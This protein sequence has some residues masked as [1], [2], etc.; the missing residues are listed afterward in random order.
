MREPSAVI[1]AWRQEG[2][3]GA[4]VRAAAAAHKRG[5]LGA[6][7][8]LAA[9][10]VIHHF[11]PVAGFVVAGVALLFLGLALTAPLTLYPKVM[12]LLDRFAHAVGTAFTWILMTV[13]YYLFFLP[14]GLLLR[15]GHKLAITTR[16]ERGLPSY[17]SAADERQRAPAAYRKQF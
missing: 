2:D 16:F 4:R 1:W 17:W 13:L 6:A 5:L 8:G 14:V 12:G 3:P 7:I 15:A 9:A 10:A 11:R